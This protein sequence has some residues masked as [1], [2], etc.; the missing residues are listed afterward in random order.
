MSDNW[1]LGGNIQ[2]PS[3]AKGGHSLHI[4]ALLNQVQL[5][6]Y[7]S[8]ASQSLSAEFEA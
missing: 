6:S 8:T 2:F 4:I 7:Q 3:L 5:D 1:H